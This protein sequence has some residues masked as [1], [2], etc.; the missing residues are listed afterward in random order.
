[1]RA[2][3]PTRAETGLHSG[4]AA[5]KNLIISFD[6]AVTPPLW[7]GNTLLAGVWSGPFLRKRCFQATA[8]SS[9]EGILFSTGDIVKKGEEGEKEAE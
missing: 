1:M 4:V 9:A 2:T 3:A 5:P 6:A 7:S 8:L